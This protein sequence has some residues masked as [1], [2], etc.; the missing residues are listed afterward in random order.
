MKNLLN[1][2]SM[3][4]RVWCCFR[5]SVRYTV[6]SSTCGDAV[7]I[8]AHRHPTVLRAVPRL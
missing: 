8:S 5:W 1:E 7:L 4:D 3:R 2:K 6:V